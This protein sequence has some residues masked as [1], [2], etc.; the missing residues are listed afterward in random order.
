MTNGDANARVEEID[1]VNRAAEPIVSAARLRAIICRAV[2][3][4]VVDPAINE[5]ELP[6]GVLTEITVGTGD[7]SGLIYRFVYRVDLK[8]AA[9]VVAARASCT[10]EVLYELTSG[11][12]LNPDSVNAFGRSMVAYTLHPYMSEAI[13]AMLSRIDIRIPPFG[14]LTRPLEKRES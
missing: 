2:S 3:A 9:G 7:P 8:N 11:V 4:E 5:I 6:T 1:A 12:E 13:T 14:P 10:Y